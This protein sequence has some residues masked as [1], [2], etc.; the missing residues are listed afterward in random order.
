MLKT[1]HIGNLMKICGFNQQEFY[2]TA[3]MD[4]YTDHLAIQLI[5]TRKYLVDAYYLRRVV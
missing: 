4:G 2:F 5:R 1:I 3:C